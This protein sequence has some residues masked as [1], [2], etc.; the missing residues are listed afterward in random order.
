MIRKGL[1][2][3]SLRTS[4]SMCFSTTGRMCSLGG[5]RISMQGRPSVHLGCS[6]SVLVI[7]FA[8]EGFW[9][10][11]ERNCLIYSLFFQGFSFI[12]LHFPGGF[13]RP[14]RL[15]TREKKTLPA[16]F[17]NSFIFSTRMHFEI[18]HQNWRHFPALHRTEGTCSR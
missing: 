4:T 17:E 3:S 12:E 6:V 14:F 1:L 7:L 16:L 9:M 18:F 10:K 11:L 15:L 13:H 5:G 8:P 2:N